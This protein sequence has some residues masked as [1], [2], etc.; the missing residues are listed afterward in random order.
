MLDD[1]LYCSSSQTVSRLSLRIDH[2]WPS[3]P[4]ARDLDSIA[5]QP[6]AILWRN[7]SSGER[8][9]QTRSALPCNTAQTCAGN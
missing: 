9:M 1:S 6:T 4:T 2:Q 8:E 3:P 7:S 5:N